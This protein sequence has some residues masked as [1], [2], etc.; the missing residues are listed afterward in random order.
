MIDEA[1]EIF[2]EDAGAI[3]DEAGLPSTWVEL[4][5]P[6][7]TDTGG[8][9]I[10]Y[11]DLKKHKTKRI[12]V[13]A[14]ALFR[15]HNIREWRDAGRLDDAL[16]EMALLCITLTEF[17][18]N[19]RRTMEARAKRKTKAEARSR[20]VAVKLGTATQANIAEGEGISDRQVARI[21]KT[22]K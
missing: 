19:R 18:V 9:R 1:L 17:G 15:C 10:P 20:R 14:Q 7:D 16:H 2:E 11:A 6:Y 12:R 21:K 3:L 4:S 22:T 5:K 8:R 13:A